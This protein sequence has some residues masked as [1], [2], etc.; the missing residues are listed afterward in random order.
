MNEFLAVIKNYAGFSGRAG[1]KEYWM[2]QLMYLLIVVGISIVGAILPEAIG[3][4]LG[5]LVL[6]VVL[7]LLIPTL[8]VSVRRLHDSDRSGWW[9][10]I[11]LIP[12]AGLYIL[13]LLIIEGTP[14]ANRFGQPVVA[15]IENAV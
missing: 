11:S 3:Q 12:L 9:L 4:M 2:F 10:L 5:I 15:K 14:G 6:V 13:Y 7:G 1:R 8:A